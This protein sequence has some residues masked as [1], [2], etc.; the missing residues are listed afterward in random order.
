VE[1]VPAAAGQDADG[2]E[3]EAADVAPLRLR[4]A[5]ALVTSLLM[6]SLVADTPRVWVTQLVGPLYLVEDT[7]Y[8]KENSI[9]YVGP[10]HVTLIG[11]T[12]TPETARLLD[13]E[14][15]RVSGKPV[16]EVV[17]TNYHPDRAGGNAYWKA[18]GA[19]IVATSLT[20]DLL[21]R[22]WDAVV[23]WTRAAI[24]DY[25]DLPV[26]MPTAVHPGD[27]ALQEGRVQVFYLGPSHT[28]DGVFVYFPEQ[29]VLYGG[30][31]LKEQLGNLSFADVVAYP[32]TIQKLQQRQLPIR[33]IVAG[34]W[35]PVHGPDLVERYLALLEKVP[36]GQ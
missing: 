28:R 29:R 8:S 6:R 18:N 17:N 24:P 14:I 21:E 13:A 7:F 20:R 4:L 26:T 36:G 23:K 30:C 2:R 33:T 27:F 31:I 34:H 35:A 11:A 16:R 10:D 32:K 22:E 3:V 19:S 15:R 25:P 12:W 1:Q 9:F 5:V